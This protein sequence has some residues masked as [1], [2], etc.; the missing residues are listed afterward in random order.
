VIQWHVIGMY[1]PSFVT[2]SLIARFGIYRILGTGAALIG[3]SVAI[4]L[5]GLMVWQFWL[6]LLVLGVGWNFLYIG[7][8]SLLTE[9]YFPEEK[10]KVQGLNDFLIFTTTMVTAFSSGVIFNNLGWGWLN[11]AVILPIALV[12]VAVLKPA[13]PAPVEAA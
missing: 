3:L 7:G 13:P 11:L 2:G 5:S 1:L 8:S 4:N 12:L 10:A 6:G 9:T